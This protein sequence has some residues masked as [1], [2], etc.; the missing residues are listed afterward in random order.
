MSAGKSSGQKAQLG[1]SEREQLE[2]AVVN[3]REKVEEEIE[4]ELEHHYKLTDREAEED[5]SEE[6][7]NTRER[8][9]EAISHENPD[10]K[11]WH[12]CYKQYITGVGYTITTSGV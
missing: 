12:W 3:L 11:S 10:D 7:L 4:Y 9:V 5:L 8:L 6:E 1:K 2:N